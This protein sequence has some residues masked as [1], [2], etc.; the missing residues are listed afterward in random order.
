MINVVLQEKTYKFA[1]NW[2]EITI[3]KAEELRKLKMPDSLA[4]AYE[5]YTKGEKFD[6]PVDEKTIIKVL[7]TYY[8]EVIRIMAHMPK[9]AVK[10][11]HWA[12]RTAI[13]KDYLEQFVVGVHH[14]PAYELTGVESFDFE[15]VT[16][17]LPKSRE[18]L[19]NKE[20]GAEMTAIEFTESADLEIYSRELDGGK[21]EVLPNIISILCR[22]EGEEYSEQVSLIRAERFKHLDMATAWEVFFSIIDYSARFAA[23]SLTSSA[24]E[25]LKQLRQQL[26]QG[27]VHS[28]GTAQ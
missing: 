1:E 26:P 16:Y 7:P 18:V 6:S 8:G 25:G 21:Y 27:S 14:F 2:G 13:Y 19:G 4:Q 10:L 11:I 15:G 28:A 5:A 20:E 12:E 9:S 23:A 17:H 24:V 3:E 22:P